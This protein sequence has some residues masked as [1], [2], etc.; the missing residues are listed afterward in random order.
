M[1]GLRAMLVMVSVFLFAWGLVLFVLEPG[2]VLE[3]LLPGAVGYETG[4]HFYLVGPLAIIPRFVRFL[5]D[6]PWF[7]CCGAGVLIT[8]AVIAT[9]V[10]RRR[11]P[12]HTPSTQVPKWKGSRMRLLDSIRREIRRFR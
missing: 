4:T 3:F 8:V 9:S 2:P 10:L 12:T 7:I 1:T 5:T 11:P 6:I